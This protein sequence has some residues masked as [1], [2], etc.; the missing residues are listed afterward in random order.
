MDTLTIWAWGR[1]PL[2]LQWSHDLSA[3]DTARNRRSCVQYPRFN[4]AMTSQPWIRSRTIYAHCRSTRFNGAMTSQPWIRKSGKTQSR[5]NRCFNGAMTSQ[6]WIL[7]HGTGGVHNYVLLQWSH[8][9]S[10]MD[11]VLETWRTSYIGKLQWSHDLSAMDTP[12]GLST[13]STAL[14]LQWSHDLSAMDTPAGPILPRRRCP[15][16]NGAM[17]SQPWIHRPGRGCRPATTCF[18]GA[19]TSQ[20][21]IPRTHKERRNDDTTAS[22]E[23]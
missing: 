14:K 12:A 5:Q 15:R 7:A 19:M 20:P 22:M 8:D 13:S 4:G 16:F 6:P 18:N 17:T 23:P 9:L 3:M 2:L 10:A 11:T 21:W 1:R